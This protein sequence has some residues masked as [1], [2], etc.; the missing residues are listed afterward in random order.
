MS[1]HCIVTRFVGSSTLYTNRLTSDPRVQA[2]VPRARRVRPRAARGARGGRLVARAALPRPRRPR[3]PQ[4]RLC[5][6]RHEG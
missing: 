1:M 4:L 5:Q 2:E 3:R 6:L